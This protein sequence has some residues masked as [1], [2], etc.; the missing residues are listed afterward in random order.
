MRENKI[1]DG[2]SGKD[3]IGVVAVAEETLALSRRRVFSFRQHSA[4]A[5]EATS[6]ARRDQRVGTSLMLPVALPAL[7]RELGVV[8]FDHS[9]GMAG[10]AA[11][12]R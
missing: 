5:A 3:A 1:R 9:L 8:P 11:G 6:P 12:I 4:M 10:N 2:M 7:A